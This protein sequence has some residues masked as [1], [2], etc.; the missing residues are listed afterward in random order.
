MDISVEKEI[1][2]KELDQIQDVE[3]IATI[4]KMLDFVKRKSS[5]LTYKPMTEDELFNRLTESRKAIAEGK[6]I[7]QEE[8]K[9]YF[10]KKNE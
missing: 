3:L 1:I 4:R 6:L 9:N 7:S 2:K 10:K 5:T 8:V